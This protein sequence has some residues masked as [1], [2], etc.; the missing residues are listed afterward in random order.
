MLEL[1]AALEL[2]KL[3]LD[4]IEL[5]TAELTLEFAI[6]LELAAIELAG[7]E[8]ELNAAELLLI[9]LPF[10]DELKAVLEFATTPVEL[11]AELL[12]FTA[13][14]LL[15]LAAKLLETRELAADDS[16]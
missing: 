10:E 12:E 15:E 5:E 6:E 14:A 1:T 2:L 11:T 4:A 3:E 16:G 8:L 13:G 7:L 9:A